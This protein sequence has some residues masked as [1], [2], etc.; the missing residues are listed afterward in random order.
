MPSLAVTV[1]V[2]VL[3]SAM[4]VTGASTAGNWL[5]LA[6]PQLSAS[7]VMPVSRSGVSTAQLALPLVFT[8][9]LDGQVKVGAWLSTTVTVC[10]QVLLLPLKS[11][12]V[13]VT[14]VGPF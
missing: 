6:V 14:T 2:N 7:L 11:V 3:P 12:A 5:R 13:Q 9:V 4:P 1:T 8:V 10:W